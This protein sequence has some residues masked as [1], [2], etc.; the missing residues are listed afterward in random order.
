MKVPLAD[1]RAQYMS[2]KPEIDS[3]ISQVI[4][5]S[6][7]ILGKAV[8]DFEQAFAQA[9]KVKYGVAVG[10]GTDALHASLWA[11]GIGTGDAVV[12]TPF[13]FIATVE[14]ISMTGAQALFVD[15]DPITY[16]MDPAKLE[17]LLRSHQPKNIK[18]VIPVHLYGHPADMGAIGDIASK[19]K[20]KVIEDACQSHLARYKDTFVGNFGAAACFSFYPGKNLGAYGEAGGILTGDENLAKK[21]RQLRDHG[22][23]EKYKHEFW[24]HNYRMDGIQGAVLG[25]KLRYLGRWTARRR[26]IAARYKEHLSGV[27]DLVMPYEAEDVFHVYHLFVV[28][29]KQRS[30]LQK[31]LAEKEIATALHYPIPIHFQEA[32]KHLGYKKGDFPASESAADEC[33]SLPMY[34]EMSDDQLDYVIT[35][36]RS[37]FKHSRNS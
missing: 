17:H 14:A 25:V 28:R 22:Q 1:L 32:Y 24:G 37:F 33:V 2:I 5:N 36:V 11:F 19:Y 15:I 8:S 13:T 27:D 3:A 31:Y 29:T 23:S 21:L 26:E 9:H 12:T 18:A 20:L 16:T 10:S 6:Q 34:A 35:N 7:F 4:E 30:Q